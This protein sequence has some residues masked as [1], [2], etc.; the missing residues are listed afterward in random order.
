VVRLGSS[1][2]PGSLLHS[3]SWGV[4]FLTSK[5]Q[6]PSEAIDLPTPSP[7]T[8]DLPPV[9]VLCLDGGGIRGR[10]QLAIV[11][12]IEAVA[13]QPASDMFDLVAGTSIGGCGALF[14]S[15]YGSDA[16]RMARAAMSELQ[17]TC[18]AD[19]SYRRLVRSGHLCADKRRDFV[20]NVCGSTSSDL[21]GSLPAFALATQ[22]QGMGFSPFLFRTYEAP[23]M[24]ELPGTTNATLWQAVDATSAAPFM[25]PPCTLPQCGSGS[26]AEPIVLADGGCL[27]NDP[28]PYALREARLLYPNRPLGMVVSIGTGILGRE[29]GSEGKRARAGEARHQKRMRLLV[30]AATPGATYYRLQPALRED[31]SPIETDESTISRMEN[32]TRRQMALGIPR[33]R[34]LLQRLRLPPGERRVSVCA[35]NHSKDKPLAR[36]VQSGRTPPVREERAVEASAFLTLVSIHNCM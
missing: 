13:G 3:F 29:R 18:F 35:N 17:H 2:T 25:F 14:M 26:D 34:M 23:V 31:V 5:L 7:P 9:N 36:R 10:N 15:K 6:A 12:E 30:R 1:R 20:S 24:S 21:S 19:R 4:L 8:E 32:D 27:A 33:A 11:E 22:R 28:L 16:T